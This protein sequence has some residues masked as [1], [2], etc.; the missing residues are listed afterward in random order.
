MFDRFLDA[1][2]WV[3]FEKVAIMVEGKDGIVIVV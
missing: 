2:H 3:H 1:G